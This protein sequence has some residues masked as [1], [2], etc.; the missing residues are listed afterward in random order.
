[1]DWLRILAVTMQLADAAYT[2]KHINAGTGHEGNK[3]MPK[4]CQGIVTQKAVFMTPLFVMKNN[5]YRKAY[6]IGIMGAGS[7]GLT[8]SIYNINKD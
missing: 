8:L 2:C 5:K 4:T 6:S 1:M 7:V 3:F